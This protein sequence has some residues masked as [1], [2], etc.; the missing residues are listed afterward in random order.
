MDPTGSEARKQGLAAFDRGDVAMAARLLGQRV[1]VA[2]QDVEALCRLAVALSRLGRHQ[3]ALA[4][5]NAAARLAG[6]QPMVQHHWGIVLAGAGRTTEAI[7]AFEAV[8]RAQPGNVDAIAWLQSL[9][10]AVPGAALQPTATPDRLIQTPRLFERGEGKRWAGIT[11]GITLRVA[12]WAFLAA[13]IGSWQYAMKGR[14]VDREERAY[15]APITISYDDF[16]SQKPRQGCF[17]LTGAALD[18]LDADVEQVNGRIDTIYIPVRRAGTQPAGPVQL[19]LVSNQADVNETVRYLQRA[20]QQGGDAGG[21][22]FAAANPGRMWVERELD[23]VVQT[24]ERV[25]ASTN[26]EL[27]QLHGDLAP[28]YRLLDDERPVPGRGRQMF[29]VGMAG[30]VSVVLIVLGLLAVWLRPT[31][32][33]PPQR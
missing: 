16:I 25:S 21:R 24:G 32:D 15:P 28:D 13:G 2:P 12:W 33:D 1:A 30:V 18:V 17:R 7:A 10:P 20:V 5:G 22:A 3:E 6:T 11:A 23:C 14:Q 27:E 19:L 8:L 31:T 9:R 26:K 4:T 29:Q